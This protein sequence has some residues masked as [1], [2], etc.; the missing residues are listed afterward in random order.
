[1]IPHRK[2][3]AGQVKR[4]GE[5]EYPLNFYNLPPLENITTEEFETFALDRLQG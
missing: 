4:H 1:M 5:F 3:K 2:L